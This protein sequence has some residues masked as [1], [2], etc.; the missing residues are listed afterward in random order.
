MIVAN[1]VLT[2][3]G[4]ALIAV[5]VYLQVTQVDFVSAVL[6]TDLVVA[7]GGL[8]IA[9]GC[10]LFILAIYGVISGILDVIT[11]YAVYFGLLIP[12]FM[13]LVAG[14]VSAL[15]FKTWLTEQV[16]YQMR[17]TLVNVYGVSLDNPWNNKVT[18]SWDKAQSLWK[19]CSIDDQSWNVYQQSAWYKEQ[20]GTPG[21][22]TNPKPYVPRSCCVTDSSGQIS[23]ANLY[24]CQNNQE[25]PPARAEGSQYAGQYNSALYYRGCYQAAQ[26]Y[27]LYDSVSW[28]GILVG[29]GSAVAILLLIIIVLA[30][31]LYVIRKREVKVK[32]NSF[33]AEYSQRSGTVLY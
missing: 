29:I 7:A 19:C 31:A 2:M 9:A 26:D 28:F 32:G 1:I 13:A 18:A 27:L 12:V 23:D 5:F 6:G 10:L 25:G 20:P 22:P 3:V 21:S 14:V 8:L 24:L 11:A 30:I 16:R 17:S 33:I 15:V 4:A